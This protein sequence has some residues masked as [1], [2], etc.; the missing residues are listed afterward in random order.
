VLAAIDFDDQP[1]LKASEVGDVRGN[2]R[3]AAE[4]PAVH[5]LSSEPRPKQA[6]GIRHL[7]AQALCVRQRLRAVAPILTG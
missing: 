6:F 1:E 7:S 4:M 5:L 2:G 3:L